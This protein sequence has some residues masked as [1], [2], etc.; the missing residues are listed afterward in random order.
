MSEER[1]AE[2]V[3]ANLLNI[4]ISNI[5][6]LPKPTFSKKIDKIREK[7]QG[8][9]I[10][11]EYPTSTVHV[12]HFEIL[13]QE[14]RIKKNFKPDII[15]VDYINLCMSKRFKNANNQ[16]SYTIVK[17]IAEELRGMAVIHNVPI[18]TA[19]QVNR[20]GANDP[21]L[22][23]T[24]T[25]DSFGLPATTDIMLALITNDNFEEAGQIMV[26]Q[27]KN[28]YNDMNYYKKFTLG[29]NRGKMHLHDIQQEEETELVD[30]GHK[31]LAS[32]SKYSG[33]VI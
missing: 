19:T 21:D 20:S 31:E 30:S 4:D 2:R 15:Y 7:F 3:D 23:L 13:L 25:A 6:N 16:N 10:I 24:N 29:I 12:G 26:K 22:D 11:K 28:R 33:F 1:I 18:V 27:L 8:Q 9:L 17:S 14:L 5:I 32:G